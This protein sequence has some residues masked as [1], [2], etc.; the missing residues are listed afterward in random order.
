MHSPFQIKTFIAELAIAPY[1]ICTFGAEDTHLQHAAAADDAMFCVSE[2]IGADAGERIDVSMGGPSE[3][4]YGDTIVRGELMT[5][6]AD[7]KAIPATGAPGAEVSY[8]GRA[9]RSGADGDIGSVL[10]APGK[11][12]VPSA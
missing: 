7:G 5:S 10:I 8:I 1:R 9:L 4:E 12:I 11:F 6:D 3:V 2:H